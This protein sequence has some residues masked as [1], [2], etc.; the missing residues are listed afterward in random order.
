MTPLIVVVGA[1]QAVIDALW[2]ILGHCPDHFGE[3]NV[4][5][6]ESNGMQ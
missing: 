6:I 1:V 5:E 4:F 2:G 3:L